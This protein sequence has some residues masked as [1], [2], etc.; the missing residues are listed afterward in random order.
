MLEGE[1]EFAR[2]RLNPVSQLAI[3]KSGEFV[4]QRLDHGRVQ[5]HHGQLE[6]NP[7]QGERYVLRRQVRG[8]H[9]AHQP[10]YKSVSG[11]LEYVKEDGK[12]RSAQDN[13]QTP[14]LEKISD[15]QGRGHLVESVLFFEDKCSVCLKRKSWEGRYQDH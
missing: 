11:P 14:A 9:E 5:D 7:V 6:N 4:E 12:E 13:G 1:L 15:E 10:W 8:L 2:Q 3:R